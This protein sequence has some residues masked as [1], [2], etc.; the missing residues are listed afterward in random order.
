MDNWRHNFHPPSNDGHALLDR[1]KK[2]GEVTVTATE[3]LALRDGLAYVM[4]SGWGKVLVE[5]DSKI[6]IDCI[7]QLPLSLGVSSC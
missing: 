2:I 6:V 3:C 4:H 7:N 1:A 5:G